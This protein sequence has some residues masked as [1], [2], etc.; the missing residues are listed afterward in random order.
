M[1]AGTARGRSIGG[2]PSNRSNRGAHQVGQG[3]IVEGFIAR[4]RAG[5]LNFRRRNKE[6]ATN[7]GAPRSEGSP[8]A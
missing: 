7:R 6:K 4:D 8:C 5:A 1:R 2:F 3:N